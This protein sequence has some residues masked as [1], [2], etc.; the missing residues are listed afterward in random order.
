MFAKPGEHNRI[1]C[2]NIVVHALNKQPL[3]LVYFS[4]TNCTGLEIV[5]NIVGQKL[6][7]LISVIQTHRNDQLTHYQ[8]SRFLSIQVQ[9]CYS[10][11]RC[12]GETDKETNYHQLISNQMTRDYRNEF[13][14]PSINEM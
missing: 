1:I 2:C 3:C 11:N 13:I 6:T 10:G 4:K 12:R 5:T 14:T 8:A 9:T 7:S